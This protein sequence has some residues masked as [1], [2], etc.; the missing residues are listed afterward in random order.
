[1]MHRLLRLPPLSLTFIA[2]VLSGCL[3]AAE[4]DVEEA[5]SPMSG[6]GS[7]GGGESIGVAQQAVTGCCCPRVVGEGKAVKCKTV[8]D[9]S[10][11]KEQ[12]SDGECNTA[13]P[14]TCSLP[15]APGVP[16]AAGVMGLVL[17]ATATATALRRRVAPRSFGARGRKA[18]S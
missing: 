11:C 3:V 9:P 5:A 6:G 8:Y 1:M 2:L 10:E 15:D 7:G 12:Y 14:P 13:P 16:G 18:R 4:P 17:F